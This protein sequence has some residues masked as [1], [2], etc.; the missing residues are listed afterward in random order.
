MFDVRQLFAAFAPRRPRDAF[1]RGVAA[2]ER[3]E[4][5]PALAEFDAALAEAPDGARRAT[6]HNKRGVAF[7]TLGERDAALEAFAR[8]LDDDERCAAA[9]TNLGNL[10]F[11]DGHVADAVDYYEAAIRAEPAYAIAHRNLGVALKRLGRRSEAVR[12]LRA[13]ARFEGRRRSERA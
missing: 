7:V 6:L 11:E 2:L 4:G 9:L 3:G 10:L 13:A 5:R 1:E 8:A 12:A